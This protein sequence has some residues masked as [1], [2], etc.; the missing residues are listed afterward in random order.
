MSK[1]FLYADKLIWRDETI[2]HYTTASG[3]DGILKNHVI[4]A[5]SAAFMND[6]QELSTGPELLVKLLDFYKNELDP[7]IVEDVLY[8]AN[9]TALTNR[10]KTF[11]SCACNDPDSLTMWRNYAGSEA[12]FAIGINGSI[13]LNIRK[14]RAFDESMMDGFQPPNAYESRASEVEAIGAEKFSWQ[15]ALYN[16]EAQAEV[17]LHALRRFEKI[18]TE[19]L[20][21]LN[22][23][24]AE[25]DVMSETAQ[26]L[27]VFK[28]PA[29]RDEKEQRI[30]CGTSPHLDGPFIKHRPGK[31][32]IVPYVE[33]GIP[34]PRQGS[35]DQGLPERMN[36]LPI[37]AIIVG[38]TPYPKEAES[39]VFDLL[40]RSGYGE[41]PIRHS[42][43]PFRR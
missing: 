26:A 29:F 20:D 33:L 4:W 8:L 35:G 22:Q 17:A 27:Q 38:P 24:E 37:E 25:L 5:S 16:L 30:V 15:P 2:W 19:R 6:R 9:A 14:Q 18:A 36:K 34:A 28:H 12:G 40:Q 3:L 11:V 32:G 1:I 41:P 43:V 23:S 10:P 42:Q 31:Y 21:G 39:G 7:R 13:G